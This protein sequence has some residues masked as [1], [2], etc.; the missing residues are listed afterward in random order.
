MASTLF[1]PA[2]FRI[3]AGVTHVC[4]GG[5]TA[6]L[7]RHD[8][9]FARYAIDKSAGPAGRVAQEAVVERA[10]DLSA[11]LFG[12]PRE[13]IGFVSSV[14]EGM[15]LLVES[16]DWRDGDNVL[17]DAS[18]YPS[19]V[20]PLSLGL[21]PGVEIRFA[22]MHDPGAVAARVHGRTRMLAVSHVSY[23]H[24]RRY[25]L[26]A[27]RKVADS[28][29][30]ML[31][32]DHTQAAGYLPLAAGEAD[33]AFSACYKWLLGMT[34][35]AIAYWNRDRQPDW[36]P[37][38]AGWYSISGS[39]RPEYGGRPTL[40]PDAMRFTRGNP[41]HPSL[42]VLVEALE[43]LAAFEARDIQSH[44]QRLT[45]ALLEHFAASG[46]PVTTP[47]D[48]VRHG[49]SVCVATPQ[50]DL[51]VGALEEEAG[52]YAW[53]GRGRVRFS[54]HGYNSIDEVGVVARAMHAVWPRLGHHGSEPDRG[55][56]SWFASSQRT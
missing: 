22:P 14:A 40:K 3:P 12:V 18:E 34:G 25:D 51:I 47:A 52:I 24:G 4:A 38:T 54:F 50:A 1:D 20:A 9:A 30:A 29:G 53:G 43:Y 42:Y 17:L 23:L 35:T 36:Q 33:F 39:A 16:L 56:A 28:V 10:R 48:P 46:I 13:S 27:L 31:V 19:V 41:S 55:Q 8:R 15:S 6:F 44:V 2:Q 37:R 32:V 26:A 5:E 21:P 49:A 11:R 7:L 45:T